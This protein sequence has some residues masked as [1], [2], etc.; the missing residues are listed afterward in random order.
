MRNTTTPIKIDHNHHVWIIRLIAP[1]IV[2]GISLIIAAAR[3]VL[4]QGQVIEVGAPVCSI[5]YY[6][7]VVSSTLGSDW[8]PLDGRSVLTSTYSRLFS[9]LGYTYG[10]SGANF[11]LPNYTG[12]FI[13][14]ATNGGGYPVG[15]SGGEI[16]HV[17][18]PAEMPNHSHYL[19]FLASGQ[20]AQGNGG[21]TDLKILSNL[22]G[23]GTNYWIALPVG[24][25]A[26]HNTMPPYGAAWA[27]I[28]AK[29][30]L[31]T[32][33]VSLTQVITSTQNITLTQ[34]V[35]M[36]GQIPYSVYTSTLSSGDIFTVERRETYGEKYTNSLLFFIC[37]LLLVNIVVT[38]IRSKR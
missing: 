23:A 34:V 20:S 27:M 37:L 3:P 38:S 15:A 16:S 2:I 12:R 36:N 22:T 24:G 6:P 29:P 35:S 28:K 14:A 21:G 1:I 30:T 25:G 33:T 18:S 13:L 8:L 19:S 17:L 10:G 26:A 31:I 7:G 5:V 32:I 11:T 4:A 9:C